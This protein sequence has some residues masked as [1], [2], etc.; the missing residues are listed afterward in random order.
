MELRILSWESKGL[1][2]PDIKVELTNAVGKKGVVSIIQMPNGTGKTTTLEL[3][4]ASLTGAARTWSAEQVQEYQSQRKPA[5]GSFRLDLSVDGSPLVFEMSFDFD[6]NRV[7]YSTTSP[8]IGGNR[9][10]WEP[11]PE[12]RRFL[13]ADFIDLVVFDGELAS[14]LLDRT[15]TNAES[16]VD[17]M[18]QLYLLDNVRSWAK[19]EKERI[20][21]EAG[22]T[23]GSQALK[24][25]TK[26][27]EEVN[28]R[29]AKVR[30]ARKKVEEKLALG[31]KTEA[32]LSEA[33]NRLLKKH[34]G[35]EQQLESFREAARKA[36]EAVDK[37]SAETLDAIR[38]PSRLSADFVLKLENLYRGLDTAKLPSSTSRQFFIELANSEECVCGRPITPEVRD[39]I[40]LR[41]TRF[42]G[43]EHAG[44]LNSIKAQIQSVVLA[45][46]DETRPAS[47]KA[48]QLVQA[49]NDL[50][51]ANTDLDQLTE[52][53]ALPDQDLKEIRV[54]LS[55]V[56]QDNSKLED[57]LDDIDRPANADDDETSNCL[58]ALNK[59][60]VELEKKQEALT[61][62][63]DV[64]E[65]TRILDDL[66]S[67]IKSTARDAIGRELVG[68]GNSLLK[69]VL[70]QSPIV[71][72]SMEK[73]IKLKS[74]ADAS[75]G[76][77]LAVGYVM[78]GSLLSR[79]AHSLPFIVDSPANPIDNT[80][81]REIA[82]ILPSLCDQFV[83]FVIS[84]EKQS[85]TDVL[86]ESAESAQF[87]TVFRKL[88]AT[89]PYLERL[90]PGGTKESDDYVL[91]D[92]REFFD[93][94]DVDVQ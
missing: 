37:V 31:K 84:S 13:H 83:T 43:Q 25:T 81:R 1:R 33:F 16:A 42:L 41:S 49:I 20:V 70:K 90:P 66:I 85:F 65:K 51:K 6:T 8:A 45:D 30:K 7:T 56:E 15:K 80:V 48:M 76:Q 79:G 86:G 35:A 63:V 24:N 18:S 78:L 57:Y 5:V 93:A 27:L 88:E 54:K 62:T 10:G 89:Q 11:P 75:V 22:V 26:R 73:H 39:N 64:G 92:G 59:F 77:K 71:I 4:R 32:E 69:S 72:E 82:R 29:I 47:E 61:D 3:L 36:K 50:G 74:Q 23:G 91:V 87:V 53:L 52:N 44:T 28:A 68:Q 34:K 17:A 9:E 38:V 12:V 67:K 21:K 40:L 46:K 19:Q 14:D 2:C 60:R 94:F 58:A 55:A